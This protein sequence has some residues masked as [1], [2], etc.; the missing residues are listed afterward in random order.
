MRDVRPLL[1]ALLLT[2]PFAC[3]HENRGAN[4]PTM[5]T[6]GSSA[7]GNGMAGKGTA[8]NDAEPPASERGAPGATNATY[9]TNGTTRF[10]RPGGAFEDSRT[11]IKPNGMAQPL[12]PGSGGTIGSGGGGG[13][14]PNA[15]TG[16]I[17]TGGS[18]VQ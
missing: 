14:G 7:A 3:S 1:I 13:I 18:I 2:A 5:G 6:A 9:A 8:G 4:S 11:T 16:A 12:P 17:S 15:G 10:N